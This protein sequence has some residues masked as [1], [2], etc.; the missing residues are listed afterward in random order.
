MVPSPMYIPEGVPGILVQPAWCSVAC[1]RLSGGRVATPEESPE[2][3]E[4]RNWGRLV[5]TYKGLVE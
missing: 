4:E 1:A 3:F 2:I 5:N